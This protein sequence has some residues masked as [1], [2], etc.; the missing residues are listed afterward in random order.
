MTRSACLF[1]QIYSDAS[2]MK[3]NRVEDF[4]LKFDRKALQAI[5]MEVRQ[6]LSV[7]EMPADNRAGGMLLREDGIDKMWRK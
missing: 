4:M 5:E 7:D 2:C 1:S 3:R 6:A